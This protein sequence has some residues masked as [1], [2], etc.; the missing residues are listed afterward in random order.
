MYF[1]YHFFILRTAYE[2]LTDNNI[3]TFAIAKKRTG[4]IAIAAVV[5]IS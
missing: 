4:A 3:D 2:M 1:L 5:T